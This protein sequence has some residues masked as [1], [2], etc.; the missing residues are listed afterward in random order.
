MLKGYGRKVKD[1]EF[2]LGVR[3]K[4][5]DIVFLQETFSLRDVEDKWA[6]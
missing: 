4:K 2:L 6:S 3:R 5:A 1:K